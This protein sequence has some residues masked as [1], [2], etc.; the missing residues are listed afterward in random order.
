MLKKSVPI[1]YTKSR[2]AD[3]RQQRNIRIAFNQYCNGTSSA[4]DYEEPDE[5]L[6]ECRGGDDCE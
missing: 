5:L 1:F 3:K 6:L 4:Y 2:M